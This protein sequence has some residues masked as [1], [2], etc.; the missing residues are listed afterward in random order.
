MFRG[1]TARSLD[2]H[3]STRAAHMPRNHRPPLIHRLQIEID[4]DGET[5]DPLARDPA[6]AL[7]EAVLLIADEPLPLRKL[8]QATGISDARRLL[9][10]L[11]D[12]YDQAGSAF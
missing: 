1:F 11:Q 7:L 3:A 6:L 8:A 12:L 5:S 4:G 9:K 2:S 10:K